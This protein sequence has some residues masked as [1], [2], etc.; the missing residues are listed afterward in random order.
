MVLCSGCNSAAMKKATVDA[1]PGVPDVT[2]ASDEAPAKPDAAVEAGSKDASQQCSCGSGSS[3]MSGAMSWTCFCSIENCGRTL[4][5][6]VDVA[7]GGRILRNQ[8][9]LLSEYADCGLVFIKH[10]TYS[11]YVPPSEYV[12]DRN[13]GVLVG[14]KVQLDDRQ[15]VCPFPP[16]DG[17]AGWVFSY[18]AGTHPIPAS[19]QV[20]ACLGSASA[21][22]GIVD[23]L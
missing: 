5:D 15:H 21:C 11:D 14:A 12:F 9:V 6:F 8:T 19:C 13:T 2:P 10:R 1:L 23:A 20:S 22:A 3:V 16:P 18:Q 17:S 7:D 4:D